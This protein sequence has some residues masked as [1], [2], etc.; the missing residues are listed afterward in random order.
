MKRAIV[1]LISNTPKYVVGQQR[2][3]KSYHDVIGVNSGIDLHTFIDE[4]SV[5]SPMHHENS[6][7]FKVYAIEKVWQL[8]YSHI[9][10]A[11]ASI[12][13]VKNPQPVFDKI[14][15]TGFFFEDS[16]HA[17]GSWCKE[18]TLS[19]F[20]ITREQAMSMAMYSS[21][22][23]GINF[24]TPAGVHFFTRWKQSMLDGHFRGDWSIHRHD[25]TCASII[26][27]QM[28]LVK[29]WASAGEYFAYIG[30]V[31]GPPKPTAVGHLLGV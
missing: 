20:G 17:I 12:A 13:F 6:Y 28:D 24:D 10:W 22:M 30:D 19:Y 14:S 23:T 21:G 11:D 16:G 18:E 5:G 1:N 26:A 2:L 4:R 31:Y 15:E 7:A 3:I 27:N 9:F 29:H 25:Q 8:G